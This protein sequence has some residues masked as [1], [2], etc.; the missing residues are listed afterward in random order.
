MAKDNYRTVIKHQHVRY[1]ELKLFA[2]CVII[3]MT[4]V[5]GIFLGQQMVY[6]YMGVDAASYRKMKASIPAAKQEISALKGELDV[7]RVQN[8]LDSTALEVVRREI[9]SQKE[10]IGRLEE[11]LLF[12]KGLMAPEDIAQGLSLRKLELLATEASNRYVFRLVAQQEALKHS[13]VKGSLSI[14]LFGRQGG[15]MKSYPLA[16]L[17]DDIEDNKCHITFPLF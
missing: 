5:L 1:R 17:S 9:A 4:L 16:Q 6:R 12:Y 11:G 15:E 13:T 10:Q 8:E 7:L 3:G 2:A 14:E